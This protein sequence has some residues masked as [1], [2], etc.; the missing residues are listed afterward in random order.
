M[1]DKRINDLVIRMAQ[2]DEPEELD[3]IA[4]ELQ[5]FSQYDYAAFARRKAVDLRHDAESLNA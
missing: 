2:E 4:D 1:D 3:K 5:E